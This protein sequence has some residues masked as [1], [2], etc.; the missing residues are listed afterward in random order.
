VIVPNNDHVRI[1]YIFV[2]REDKSGDGRTPHD[3]A[4]GGNGG[5]ISI[6]NRIAAA[7]RRSAFALTMLGYVLV[8]VGVHGARFLA[9]VTLED[10]IGSH[11]CSLEALACM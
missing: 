5:V 2:Y 1:R 10:A 11:T 3:G 8:L 6:C 4:A 9:E 7:M